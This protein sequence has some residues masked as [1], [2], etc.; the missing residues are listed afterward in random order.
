MASLF[1]P[2]LGWTQTWQPIWE[3]CVCFCVSE[4]FGTQT[5]VVLTLHYI[6]NICVVRLPVHKLQAWPFRVQCMIYTL[7]YSLHLNSPY[8]IVE[9]CEWSILCVEV[10]TIWCWVIVVPKFWL[11]ATHFFFLNEWWKHNGTCMLI[12]FGLSKQN[13][14]TMHISV[15]NTVF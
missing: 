15:C 1:R 6:Y 14:A 10:D 9:L 3:G 4:F 7:N 5:T 11:W 12:L 2:G 8:P 13:R